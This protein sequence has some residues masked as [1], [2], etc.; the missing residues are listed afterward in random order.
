MRVKIVHVEDFFDPEAGYQVNEMVMV[1]KDYDI[2]SYIITSNSMKAFHKN[3]SPEKDREFEAKTRS[4]VI[5]LPVIFE[6][7][8]R[9]ILKGLFG[10]IRELNPDLVF[11]HGIGDFKDLQLFGQRPNYVVVRDCHMSWVAARNRFRRVFYALYRRTF[12]PVINKTDRYKVIFATSL[13]AVDYLKHIGI[14]DP[15]IEYLPLGFNPS[16]MYYDQMARFE[17]RNS[18]G[19]QDDDI[20]ISYIGK[21]D[22]FKRPDLLIDIIKLLGIEF[23]KE[24]KLALLFLGPKDEQYEKFFN[25]KLS[26]LRGLK[27]IVD[28]YKPFSHLYKYFSASDICVF[29]KETTL[30]SI[31]A[32]VCGCRVLMENHK[33]N[34]ERALDEVYLYQPDNLNEAASRLRRLVEECDFSRRFPNEAWL[35]R[36]DYNWQIKIG[37]EPGAFSNIEHVYTGF[38]PYDEMMKEVSKAAFSLASFKSMGREDYKND[39]WALPHKFYDS[40]AAGTPVVVMQSSVSMSKIVEELGIGVVIEPKDVEGSVKKI[41]D[42]Y[43]NHDKLVDNVERHKNKFVWDETKEK[44]FVEFVLG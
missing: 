31:H 18:Y 13:E 6:Y 40:I 25:E 3:L 11:F 34:Q 19:L 10:K 32:Q 4:T 20:L 14:S 43:D 9:L 33:A 44:E 39:L 7:S 24:R 23:A 5:R 22:F 15:K 16:T 42:A 27:C 36:F 1:S 17:V 35:K 8:R 28:G 37:I 41:L 30:S 21:F 26:Q 29:P 12:A 2:D 38:L